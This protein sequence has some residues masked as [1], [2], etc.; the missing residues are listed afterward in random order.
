MMGRAVMPLMELPGATVQMREGWWIALSGLPTAD[1][2]M[3]LVHEAGEAE[4]T[5][6]VAQLEAAACPA[7]LMLAGAARSLGDRLPESWAVAGTMP[8]MSAE[9]AVTQAALDERVRRAGA[10]DLAVVSSLLSQAYAIELTVVEQL[11]AGV[12]G[13]EGRACWGARGGRAGERGAGVLRS[14]GRACRGA[15]GRRDSG[16]WRMPKSPSARCSA[17]ASRRP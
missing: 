8:I 13:S 17:L 6:V 2:N 14:E 12:L 7:L 3:A 16:C 5:A 10:A 15:R 9:L 4:L 1:M 11:V